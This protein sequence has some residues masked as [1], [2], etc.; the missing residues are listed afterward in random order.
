MSLSPLTT[1][2][3]SSRVAER[4]F[5]FADL[6]NVAAIHMFIRISKFNEIDTS[7]IYYR[8]WRDHPAIRTFAPRADRET[9]EL[10]SVRFSAST[11]LEENSWG[12]KEPLGHEVATPNEM[13]IVL[14]PLLC[15]D[16]GGHRVGYGKGFYDRFLSECRPDCRKIGL[17]LFPPVDRIDDTHAG[18]IP[19]DICIT[20]DRIYRPGAVTE[21]IDLTNSPPF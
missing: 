3:Q 20:P 17:S 16:T 19:L 12:I 2:E 15:F 6:S 11:E 1:A 10:E 7:I 5:A 9:G 21:A 4:F 13:D 8:L 14:V 18:D